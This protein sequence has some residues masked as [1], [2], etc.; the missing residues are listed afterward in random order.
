ME[1]EKNLILDAG[2][3]TAKHEQELEAMGCKLHK[4]EE[5]TPLLQKQM[6]EGFDP[7]QTLIVLPG[8]GA[9]IV[10]SYCDPSWLNLWPHRAL[11]KAKRYWEPGQKPEVIVERIVPQDIA[12]G[13]NDIV[14]MD[15]VI[16]SGTTCHRLYEKNQT[17]VAQARWSA[18]VWIKQRTSDALRGYHT[19]YAVRE[20]GTQKTKA[21]INSLSTLLSDAN[22]AQGFANG[23]NNFANPKLL[24]MLLEEIRKNRENTPH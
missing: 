17:W 9:Q 13:I 18:I 14:V 23:K 8:N 19:I 21:P 5:M 10:Q 4:P 3:L 2:N 16:S 12:R 24:L 20:V 7:A 11:V 6:E 15:D 22:I 1:R